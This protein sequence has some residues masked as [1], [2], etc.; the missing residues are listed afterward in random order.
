MGV[1]VRDVL[2]EKGT[3]YAELDLGNPKWSDDDLIGFMLQRI[4]SSSTGLSWSRR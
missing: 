3:P 2:R 4:P 1:P